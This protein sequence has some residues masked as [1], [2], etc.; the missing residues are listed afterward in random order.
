MQIYP[1]HKISQKNI[2]VLY[3]EKSSQAFDLPDIFIFDDSHLIIWYL[4]LSIASLYIRVNKSLPDGFCSYRPSYPQGSDWFRLETWIVLWIL[5]V[6]AKWSIVPMNSVRLGRTFRRF[7]P[8]YDTEDTFIF[9]L[10]PPGS[11][12]PSMFFCCLFRVASGR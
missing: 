7:H 2:Q 6:L 5:C 11:I 10:Y 8:C 9:I 1:L 4:S 12:S 3:H